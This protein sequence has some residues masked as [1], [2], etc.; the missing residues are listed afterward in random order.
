MQPAVSAP[1]SRLAFI[2]NRS[3]KRHDCLSPDR[4]TERQ[5]SN[6]DGRARAVCFIAPECTD[7]VAE[8]V[9]HTSASPSEAI[10]PFAR[11][12]DARSPSLLGVLTAQVRG[13]KLRRHAQGDRQTI[14]VGPTTNLTTWRKYRATGSHPARFSSSRVGEAHELLRRS[15]E[16]APRT[17]PHPTAADQ[18]FNPGGSE[19]LSRTLSETRIRRQDRCD[20]RVAMRPLVGPVLRLRDADAGLSRATPSGRPL[21]VTPRV[22]TSPWAERCST[23]HIVLFILTT[24]LARAARSQ[25]HHAVWDPRQARLEP[26]ARH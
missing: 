24:F 4:N 26:A 11:S 25:L 7:H 8:A 15:F 19:S 17:T 23:K 2:A 18:G 21:L 1:A 10:M 12:G 9:H 6:P 22:L 13:P 3:A 14:R 20:R 5:L 16:S